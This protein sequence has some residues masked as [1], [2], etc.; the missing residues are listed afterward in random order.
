MKIECPSAQLQ[1]SKV[2]FPFN[3]KYGTKHETKLVAF[4]KI[5]SFDQKYDKK[6]I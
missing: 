1:K 6:D 2:D 4:S 5:L 3:T